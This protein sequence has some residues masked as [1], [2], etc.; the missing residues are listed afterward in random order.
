MTSRLSLNPNT[1]TSQPVNVV[2]RLAPKMMPMVLVRGSMPALA[3]AR[4]SRLTIELL[5]SKAVVTTPVST[6]PLEV[7]VLDL[8]HRRIRASL[9]FRMPYSSWFMPNRKIPSPKKKLSCAT[10]ELSQSIGY[11]DSLLLCDVD[12][13]S[14]SL[15]GY[16]PMSLSHIK[17]KATRS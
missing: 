1:A 14:T 10:N 6:L 12:S 3:K 11:S 4:T 13:N 9:S 2:P 17:E 15:L 16:S 5:C 7:P 8:G